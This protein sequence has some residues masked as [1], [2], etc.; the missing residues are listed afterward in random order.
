MQPGLAQSI[1][2]ERT[3]ASR[4]QYR[5]EEVIQN[6]DPISLLQSAAEELTFEASEDVEAK[7]IEER[8]VKTSH[9]TD[10]RI[11]AV[12]RVMRELNKL[13][14]LPIEKLRRFMSQLMAQRN[15]S[16]GQ[17]LKHVRR[18][19]SDVSHQY[20]ALL[21][22]R[23]SL[24]KDSDNKE[25]EKALGDAI[26]Q[27][28]LEHGP[29]I[30]AGLNVSVTAQTFADPQLGDIQQLRD[31]YRETV[32]GF[33]NLADTYASVIDKYGE[34]DFPKALAFLL[35]AAGD[36]F[37]AKGPSLP[38][39]ELKTII[40][41]MY[42]LEVL[43]GLQED[44]Q[45]LV[46]KLHARTTSLRPNYSGHQLMRSVLKL[47][48]ERWLRA[49]QISA[50]GH[51]MGL[52]DD[53]IDSVIYFLREFKDLVRRVP[54]KAYQNPGNREKLLDAVQEALDDA[55]EREEE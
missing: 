52:N 25:L 22:A 35:K 2:L 24:S 47:K 33:D 53:E 14:D 19:F 40:D 48:E 23:E 9:D 20:T 50:L 12:E 5:G 42:R 4:G 10:K 55:I 7:E 28:T 43:T 41:D 11:E 8:E 49:D 30:R 54:L 36:D 46:T 15:Q 32:I 37:A 13:P 44:S 17:V 34:Q 26:D 1:P 31:F 21:Y 27:L 29:K 39:L 6:L 3:D 16:S 51:E 38:K 18:E 45:T